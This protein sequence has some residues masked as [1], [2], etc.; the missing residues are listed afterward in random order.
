MNIIDT[1]DEQT[2]TEEEIDNICKKYE[3]FI[4]VDE[5]FSRSEKKPKRRFF[6]KNITEDILDDIEIGQNIIQKYKLALSSN[7]P[8]N[9]IYK[10]KEQFFSIRD[11]LKKEDNILESLKILKEEYNI[12][13]KDFIFSYYFSNIY[14]TD[15][16]LIKELNKLSNLLEEDFIKDTWEDKKNRFNVIFEQRMEI[17]KKKYKK[18]EEFYKEINQ[19][20]FSNSP[21]SMNKSMVLNNTKSETEIK[22]KDYQL[23]VDNG[24]IIFNDIKL[25]KNFPYMQYNSFDNKFYKIFNTEI[26]SLL[27]TEEE[28]TNVIYLL[29][30]LEI[31]NKINYL[32]ITFD[33]EESKIS[34]EYPYDS[35]FKIYEDLQYLI[36][37]ITFK[38]EKI[39]SIN[40]SF[41]VKIDNYDELNFYYLSLFDK[42][43]QTFLY[44]NETARPRS[45]M[46][47][48]KYY[49]KNLNLNYNSSDYYLSFRLEKIYVNKYLVVFKSKIFNEENN[50][51]EFS[52]IFSKLIAY[53]QNYDFKNSD[54]PIITTPYTGKNGDGLGDN[55]FK[56]KNNFSIRGNKLLELKNKTGSLFPLGE[57]GRRCSCPKQPIVIEPEDVENWKKYVDEGAISIYPPPNSEDR[58]K[59]NHIFVCPTENNIVNYILNP[60]KTSPFPILPCCAI[61][62]KN[63]YYD[64][65]D[66]IKNNPN[67]FFLN[68]EKKN[69]SLQLKTISPLSVEQE[70]NLPIELKQLLKS[71]YKDSEFVRYG[72]FKNSKN[73]FF[74]CCMTA[75]SHLNNIQKFVEDERNICNLKHLNKIRDIYLN[76]NIE[77]RD[78]FVKKIKNY[79]VEKKNIKI[80]LEIVYQEMFNYDLKT[81]EYMLENEDFD[82][83]K[84][85]KLTEYLF[86]VNIFVF[87]YNDG[88]TQLEKP[89]HQYFHQR[90]IRKFL[91]S[92]IIFKHENR[93]PV[94]YELIKLKDG[95]FLFNEKL[96][97]YME[98]YINNHGY[99]IQK[100][101]V[102][103]KNYYKED[104]WNYILRN[105]EI[106]GQFIN[107]SGRTYAFNFKYNL[108]KFAT[109]FIESSY[110]LD[111][112]M[113]KKVYKID[114]TDVEKLFGKKYIT[115]SEGYWYDC[116]FIPVIGQSKLKSKICYNFLI[117]DRKSK[118]E[119]K[120]KKLN[121]IKKN[122]N[123]VSQIILWI[124]NISEEK[125]LDKWFKR[126]IVD[127][128]KRD[129]NSI[130]NVNLKIDYQFPLGINTPEEA[131]EHYSDYIPVIFGKNKIFLYDELREAI[132]RFLKNYIKKTEGYEKTPNKAIV[133][134][135]NNKLDFNKKTNND[136]IVGEEKY[137]LWTDFNIDFFDSNRKLGFLTL[138]KVV[139][140]EK[141]IF[142]LQNNKKN[143]LSTS[144][145][146]CKIWRASKIK[147]DYKITS[148][149]IWNKLGE[150]EGLLETLNLT[151]LKVIEKANDYSKNIIFDDFNE[152]VNFLVKEKIDY[153][154]EKEEYNYITFNYDEYTNKDNVVGE[155]PYYIFSF[156]EEKYASMLEL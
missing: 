99:Y 30:R 93:D 32:I 55:Y 139:R 13:L 151:E 123:I 102:L 19:I 107:N 94:D 52:L 149:N 110:P 74:H 46:K 84:F 152:S 28:K 58:G 97:E 154:L 145:L 9:L 3:D 72:T 96:T 127:G 133:G 75:C 109:V 62:N 26:N 148:F 106:V 23:S 118:N 54:I 140:D 56:E 12:S 33:L 5:I 116:I 63:L 91:P 25:N 150:I 77:N 70:G 24:S 138:A 111:V 130:N 98:N 7:T 71:I 103:N 90:E 64:N 36:P 117:N 2:Y 47:N 10:N 141:D 87:S 119:N 120:F 137:D 50:I 143:S 115:G 49:F 68:L 14:E 42:K 67:E 11:L 8:V 66:E 17:T 78:K 129:I 39:V 21:E 45:L 57:Y 79:I 61:R 59:I 104:N 29:Y 37:G 100:D 80:N 155:N 83:K 89:N 20:P 125:N 126:F 86:F 92:I 108:D 73:S 53:Y 1:D 85:Y 48:I 114:K 132:Y 122:S 60:D 38:E 144:L 22:I 31:S 82:S 6:R 88:L 113:T 121:N 40:G 112:P 101:N 156:E 76:L 16:Y 51:K 128:D 131:I 43:F 146:F 147:M 95:G 4:N 153:E 15:E 124:W 136:I 69:S 105:Y 35:S 142:I 34:F 27:E 44:I 18:I 81:I 41:E 65:Y 135:F 134:L